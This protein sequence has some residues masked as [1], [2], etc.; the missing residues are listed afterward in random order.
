MPKQAMLSL[1]KLDVDQFTY[2]IWSAGLLHSRLC[3]LPTIF[4]L[5]NLP[6]GLTNHADCY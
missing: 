2:R 5:A 6:E 3:S 4:S 1:L